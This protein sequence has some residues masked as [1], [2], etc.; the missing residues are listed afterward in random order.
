M[1]LDGEETIFCIEGEVEFQHPNVVHELIFRARRV[2]FP[3]DGIYSFELR[4]DGEILLESRFN[5]TA[6]KT[7]TDQ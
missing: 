6:M 2:I 7:P 4:T 3:A 5:V 1:E